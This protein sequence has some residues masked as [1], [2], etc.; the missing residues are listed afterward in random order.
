MSKFLKIFFTLFLSLILCHS[1]GTFSSSKCQWSDDKSNDYDLN[2]LKK[3]DYWKVKD[4]NGDSG[5]FAMDYLFNFCKTVSQKC[6]NNDVAALEALE[7]LGQLTETCEIL[8]KNELEQDQVISLIDANAADLGLKITYQNGDQCT[9]SE[10]PSENGLMRKIN[11]LVFC[12]ENQENNFVQSKIN[13]NTI[14]KCNLEFSIKSPAGCRMGYGSG[15]AKKS[16]III[17]WL[18][19]VFLIY[20]LSGY[21]Y[22]SKYKGKNGIE[23]FPNLEFWK[24]LPGLIKEGIKFSCEKMNLGVETAKAKLNKKNTGRSGYS[25]V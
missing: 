10:N 12:A 3:T 22:N 24:E 5:L 2:Y 11:F 19:V 16:S 1:S 4:G 15:A 7:V 21:I 14:T 6:K 13:S 23:A 17:F 20:V 18:L 8:G 9:G 25:V